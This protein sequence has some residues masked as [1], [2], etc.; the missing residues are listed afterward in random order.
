[1][2]FQK[3]AQQIIALWIWGESTVREIAS[4]TYALLGLSEYAQS[5]GSDCMIAL[6]RG[7]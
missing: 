2:N 1:V 5:K 4:E 3:L 7:Y 6:Q